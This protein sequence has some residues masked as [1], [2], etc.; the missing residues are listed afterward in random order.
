MKRIVF[1]SLLLVCTFTSAQLRTN[2]WELSGTRIP[3][4][5][6]KQNLTEV[7]F[8][9]GFADTLTVF[10][11]MSFFI[12]NSSIS[13][14]LGNLLFYSNG[15]WIANRNHDSLENCNEFNAGYSTDQYYDGRGLGFTQGMIIIPHPDSIFLYDLFYITTEKK[16]KYHHNLYTE[17]MH[18][19]HSVIDMR[20]DNGL[21]AVTLKNEYLI[22]DTLIQGKLSACKHAN[23]KDWWI[24]DH[25][26]NSTIFYTW[27]LTPTGIEGP[28]SQSIGS[29]IINDFGPGEA[30]FSSDGSQYAIE[31]N[32]DYFIE[33][34]NFDRCTGQLSNPYKF[35]NSTYLVNDF[36]GLSFSPNNEFLYRCSQLNIIQYDTKVK[37]F[38]NYP[39][40]VA[41]YDGTY[42]PFPTWFSMTQ[43]ALDGRIYICT[44]DGDS[45]LTYI[46]NPDI[47]G[48]ACS[49]V[50]HGIILPYL[51]NESIPY[52]PNYDLSPLGNYVADAGANDTI[53]KGQTIQLGIPPVAGVKYL[54]HSDPTLSD[55]TIAQPIASPD[56]TTTYYLIVTDTSTYSSCNVREDTVTVF[57]DIADAVHIPKPQNHGTFR[58]S[59]NPVSS[60][61]NMIYQSNDDAVFELFDA[62]GSRKA[63]INLYHY[64]KNRMLDIS[65]L[66]AGIYEWKVI[67]RGKSIAHGKVAVIR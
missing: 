52:F 42:A 22:E 19:S 31:S 26:W 6:N 51:N 36:V 16:F 43:L 50:Q 64:F 57:L 39:D 5:R 34:Y 56:T 18:L 3:D 30:K 9:T 59:P 62:F 47:M 48:I 17:A 21:G 24:I 63:T 25:K 10:R 40:T 2:T 7:N 11:Q 20:L 28:Y 35:F 67:Q 53:N 12:T 60:W 1:A 4:Y 61:L 46:D 23:G 44:W 33:H 55:T 49:V 27:L 8:I 29:I 66:P 45:V 13:D 54:W 38:F 15:Q 32:Y 41:I 14:S 37:N 58:V 65:A